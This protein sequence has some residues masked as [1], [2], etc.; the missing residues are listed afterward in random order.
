[1]PK[2]KI[3]FID[4]SFYHLNSVNSSNIPFFQ[5]NDSVRMLTAS[6]MQ[7]QAVILLKGEAP[8]VASG[9]ENYLLNNASLSVKAE[10]AGI[11]KYVDS[12][13]IIIHSLVGESIQ[14][15]NGFQIQEYPINQFLVTNTNCLLTSVPLVKKGEKIEAGQIIA[16]GSYHDRQ[17]LA[18]GHNLRVA[19]MC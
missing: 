9:I 2:E 3:N 12:E 14:K 16:C 10:S 6:N 8:L 11:V 4:T 19:F 7:K 5:H 13:K 15:K 17:E 18:L 1:M